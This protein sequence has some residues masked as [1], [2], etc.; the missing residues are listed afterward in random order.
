MEC[1][2]LIEASYINN[3]N[4]EEKCFRNSYFLNAFSFK[5][6]SLLYSRRKD[7]TQRQIVF[8][9]VQFF[10]MWIFSLMYQNVYFF[11]K[12]VIQNVGYIFAY[13]SGAH[14]NNLRL[15]Y[16]SSLIKKPPQLLYE[17]HPQST[18]RHKRLIEL[19]L[20][21][22]FDSHFASHYRGVVRTK[23]I[24]MQEDFSSFL[25]DTQYLGI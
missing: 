21:L 11:R 9:F 10:Y 3:I 23:K 13:F 4:T 8:S 16:R 18:I 14:K 1:K 22:K 2:I 20:I 7:K 5:S 24:F 12:I 6:L 17:I 19:D 25:K 15:Q